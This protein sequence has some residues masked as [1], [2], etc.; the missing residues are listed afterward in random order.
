K[1]YV[2]K[3]GPS[4]LGWLDQRALNIVLD[5]NGVE[6]VKIVNDNRD[7]SITL[8]DK[9]PELF[10]GKI[11][12]LKD[13]THRIVLKVNAVPRVHKS[14][15]IPW[16]IRDEVNKELESLL[17]RGIIEEVDASEWISPLVAVRKANGKIRLCIDLRYLNDNIVVERFPLPRISE[18]IALTKNMEWFTSIDLPSAY[19]QVRLHEDSKNLTAFMTPQGCF[20]YVRMPFGLASAAAVFQKLMHKLFKDVEGV[21]VFQD[22]ILIMGKNRMQ[23][24]ERVNRVLGI[25]REKG[26]TAEFSKCTFGVQHLNYLGH[27]ITMSGIR[28]KKE[29]L[30]AIRGA[31]SPNNKD[32]LRSFLG[33]AEFY[34]RFVR[35]FSEK[36]FNL[37]QLLKER[38]KF[39]WT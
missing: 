10:S 6:Q 36:T 37:R 31:P 27:E 38:C 28:P 7:Y 26:L 15:N 34:A 13:F 8:R 35:N 11:G 9:F 2:A 24:D 29:L 19:H 14:R 25:Q 16:V 21:I 17:Q 18:M 12:A 33:L 5:P 20:R 23:H 1:L 22:D 3:E 39:A 4:V 32:E 30:S